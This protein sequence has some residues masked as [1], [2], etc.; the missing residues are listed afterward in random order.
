ML[1]AILKTSLRNRVWSGATLS[2]NET[3]TPFMTLKRTGYL[4][5]RLHNWVRLS[6]AMLAAC[7]VRPI[8]AHDTAKLVFQLCVPAS[9]G[10]TS[11]QVH[12][13]GG[14]LRGYQASFRGAHSVGLLHHETQDSSDTLLPADQVMQLALIFI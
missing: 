10:A 2:A 11:N 12:T 5:T 13:R 7:G 8:F 4:L 6:R 3:T 1:P 9:Q 14:H